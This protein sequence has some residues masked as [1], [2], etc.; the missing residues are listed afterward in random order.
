MSPTDED[1]ERG[2]LEAAWES[3]E[4]PDGLVA[5]CFGGAIVMEVHPRTLHDLP[6]RTMVRQAWPRLEAWGEC[7]LDCG[8][9]GKP[10]ADVVFAR[11][12]DIDLAW[13][14][15]PAGAVQGVCEVISPSSKNHDRRIKA[16]IYARARIP[17]YLIVDPTQGLWEIF[18]LGPADAYQ[19]VG[20]G[21]FGEPCEL[22]LPAGAV[23]VD[24]T[25]W[26]PYSST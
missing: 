26:R 23:V 1:C 3:F 15:W 12:D 11:P 20:K 2:R 8:A 22:P 10:R 16:E 21:G 9:D 18:T 25:A 19:L 13:E 7:G 5:Q 24:T 14:D 6:I 17:V 4:C